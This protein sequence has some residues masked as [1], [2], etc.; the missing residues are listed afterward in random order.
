MLGR[1]KGLSRRAGWI[2]GLL[3]LA[4]GAPLMQPAR[5]AEPITVFAA[6]SLTDVLQAIGEA[7]KAKTGQDVRF[8]FASSSTLGAA[9]RGRRA[10]ANLRIGQR[11]MDGLPPGAGPH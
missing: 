4:M 9:N 7:Y 5:A 10:G 2:A 8:S 6:T 1:P 11:E 3:A